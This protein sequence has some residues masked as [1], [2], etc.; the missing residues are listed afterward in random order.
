MIVD[1]N[2]EEDPGPLHP[3][4]FNSVKKPAYDE[5][6]FEFLSETSLIIAQIYHAL[7][8]RY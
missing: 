6:A 3:D 1:Q 4:H 7:R 5:L 2:E 8:E